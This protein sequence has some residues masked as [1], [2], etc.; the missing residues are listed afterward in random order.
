MTAALFWAITERVLVTHYRRFG[1]YSLRNGPETR[2]SERP[3]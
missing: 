3:A 2:S 1:N